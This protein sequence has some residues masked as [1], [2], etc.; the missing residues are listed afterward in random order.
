MRNRRNRARGG[1]GRRST[2]R[3]CR[4]PIGAVA[5]PFLDAS[6][7]SLPAPQV[8]ELGAPHLALPG[9][10][11]RFDQRGVQRKDALDADSR[12]DAADREIG[13]RPGAV[14]APD[15][16]PLEC[17]HSLTGALPNAEVDANRVARLEFRDVFVDFWSDEFRCFH[18]V[19][20]TGLQAT[21]GSKLAAL[22]GDSTNKTEIIAQLCRQ[23][24]KFERLQVHRAIVG[25]EF[26]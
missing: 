17:L 3:V 19:S 5:R 6:G 25:N 2:F 4:L 20:A 22:G 18:N 21:R 12:R 16:H 15:A 9:H 11:Q 8:I 1:S 26:V 10:F 24:V 13:G 14:G 7:A 23:S